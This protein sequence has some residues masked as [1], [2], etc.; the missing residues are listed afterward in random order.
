MK[1]DKQSSKP[2]P[3]LKIKVLQSGTVIG[4]AKCSKGLITSAP[5]ADAELL[6][7]KGFVQ[8]IGV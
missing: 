2:E 6:E 4:S 3:M 8:I 5:K 7:E 1:T